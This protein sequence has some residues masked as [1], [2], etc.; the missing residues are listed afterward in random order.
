MPR[1][2][3]GVK[4]IIPLFFADID[5]FPCVTSR[6]DRI[7]A[8]FN[9]LEQG[10]ILVVK[11]VIESWYLAGLDSDACRAFRIPQLNDT[12]GITEQVFNQRIPKKFKIR[13]DFMVEIL[14]QYD[15]ETARRK[16]ESFAYATYKH[17]SSG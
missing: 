17:L 10:K 11:P 16:N 6:K 14:K 1:H 12:S 5:K 3:L 9:N 7:I 8:K 15:I 4:Y 2:H 13:R